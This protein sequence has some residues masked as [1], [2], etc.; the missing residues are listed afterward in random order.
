MKVILP[1]AV[2]TRKSSEDGLEQ[3]FNSLDAQ[4]EACAAFILSQ[5]EQGWKAIDANYDDGGF[6]G[7][8]TERPALKRLLADVALG[9]IKIVVVY[10]VDRLTRS[11]ADFAK[12]VELFDAHG[13]SF[14]SVTQQF[15]TTSSMGRLTLNVLLSFAQFEREV[16]GERIRDKIAASKR[17]GMWM[18]G[19]APIGYLPKDRTL[20][21]D[22]PHAIRVRQIYALYL[23]LGCVR[24]LKAELTRL[25]WLTPSR[26]NRNLDLIGNHPFSRGHLYRILSNPIYNGQI[27]H[28]DAVFPGQHPAIVDADTWI[29]VQERLKANLQ[30][31]RTRVTAVNP[32]LLTGM[33][34]D[35]LGNPLTPTHGKKGERRYRYYVSRPLHENG[36]DAAPDALRLPAQEL[37]DAVVQSLVRF[38]KNEQ[39]L[40][41]LMGLHGINQA[42][43]VRSHLRSASKLGDEIKGLNAS[44]KI[45]VLQRLVSQITVHPEKLVIAMNP[46]ALWEAGD[47]ASDDN[48]EAEPVLIEVP[49]VLKRCGMAVRLIVR[50][51]GHS[52][53]TPDPKLIGLI[54]KAHDWFAKLSSGQRDG[55][56]AIANEEQVTGSYVSRVIQLAFL[57]PDIVH[58]IHRGEQPLELNARQ[59]NS[60]VPLPI[61][62]V[63]QR[64]VLGLVS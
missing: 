64:K 44:E 7:G 54:G 26:K 61:D 11:L 4:R 1:C 16:T 43:Q 2:Y 55:V 51:T 22:E 20:V 47:A 60:M 50:A 34:F 8:N 10:K 24:K 53:R 9:R 63:E 29:A 19:T 62:W 59:L 48:R 31:H 17:K 14:V 39:R 32:S 6:S 36:P 57:A 5:K 33:V 28:K 21:I 56:A 40:S 18:G 42:V 35:H 52:E 30:G 12:L 25:G 46:A 27:A 45:E 13:V 49:V 3:G 15:N 37:E 38:L 41:E 58:L 23:Q